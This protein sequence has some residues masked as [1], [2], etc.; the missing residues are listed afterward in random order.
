MFPDRVK[1]YDSQ[2]MKSYSA[3]VLV[4]SVGAETVAN[5]LCKPL[6]ANTTAPNSLLIQDI[7]HSHNIFKKCAFQIFK[8]NSE[9]KHLFISPK[10]NKKRI[11]LKI[12]KQNINLRVE[13]K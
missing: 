6:R 13:I 4:S 3:S 11:Q 10:E 1:T 9:N 8:K 2:M 12:F 5:S 7:I